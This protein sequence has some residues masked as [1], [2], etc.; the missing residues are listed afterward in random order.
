MRDLYILTSVLLILTKLTK[1]NENNLTKKVNVLKA[2]F[3][4]EL[5]S[6]GFSEDVNLTIKLILDNTRVYYSS[7]NIDTGKRLNTYVSNFKDNL[8]ARKDF[9]KKLSNMQSVMDSFEID[10]ETVTNTSDY[11]EYKATLQIE[12]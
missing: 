11:R 4:D 12:A 8:L 9:R 2:I 5:P 7:Y 3:K 10:I 1:H 6:D